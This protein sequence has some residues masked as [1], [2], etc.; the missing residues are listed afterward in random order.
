MIYKTNLKKQYYN[1][2]NTA[3]TKK[4]W[5]NALDKDCFV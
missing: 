4:I 1:I 3:D 2:K 5:K